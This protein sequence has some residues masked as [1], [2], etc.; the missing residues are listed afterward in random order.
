MTVN[1]VLYHRLKDDSTSEGLDSDD[2]EPKDEEEYGVMY[3][4]VAT[5]VLVIIG[6]FI[7]IFGLVTMS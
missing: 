3:I 7:G 4:V 6:F 5:I 2:V 1:K